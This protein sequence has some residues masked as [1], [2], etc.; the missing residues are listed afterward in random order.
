MQDFFKKIKTKSTVSDLIGLLIVGALF[1]A[2]TEAA[3]RHW[4]MG[5]KGYRFLNGL[6]GFNFFSHRLFFFLSDFCLLAALVL[7]WKKYRIRG[8]TFFTAEGGL[9]LY[10]LSLLV[11]LSL[12]FS[13]FGFSYFQLFMAVNF[14]MTVFYYSLV[15]SLKERTDRVLPWI[16][17]GMLFLAFFQ[18]AVGFGQY[19]SQH[20]LGLKFLHEPQ[21]S[22]GNFQGTATLSLKN[23]QKWLLETLLQSQNHPEVARVPGTLPHP[24]NFGAFFFLSLLPSL[25]FLVFQKFKRKLLKRL[26][27][28]FLFLQVFALLLSFSRAALFALVLASGFGFFYTLFKGSL[29]D[30]QKIRKMAWRVG[31]AVL[32]AFGLLFP[33]Y[34]QRGGV[35]SYPQ[36]ARGSDNRRMYYNEVALEIV[37]QQ[38]LLGIGFFGFEKLHGQFVSQEIL[39]KY[40][41]KTI[42]GVIHNIYFLIAAEEGLL[43]LFCFLGFVGFLFWRFFTLPFLLERTLFFSFF[44]GVL[45]IGFCDFP[46]MY[47]PQGR[48]FFFLTPAL[49][50]AL[51]LKEKTQAVLV[52]DF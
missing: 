5:E 43:G 22:V 38:P 34:Y 9:W 14:L 8:L 2:M 46:Y 21:F 6:A 27:V 17:G 45:W 16:F 24:N 23:G 47:M 40:I 28:V 19:F 33:Q 32:A 50:S 7:A 52:R 37:K 25:Y 18:M 10:F 39:G 29:I 35:V 31:L 30:R 1:F 13:P 48:L 49:F 51:A 20:S 4:Q 44:L 42:G 26:L 15:V 11:F 41:D 3:P 36:A 12:F